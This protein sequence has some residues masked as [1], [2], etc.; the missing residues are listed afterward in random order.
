MLSTR[1]TDPVSY[2][3]ILRKDPAEIKA[4]LDSI[5]INVSEFFR[6]QLLWD[7]MQEVLTKL[8]M[9]KSKATNT[10]LRIWSAACSHGEEPYTIAILLSEALDSLSKRTSTSSPLIT[11]RATDIDRDAINRAE[12]GVYPPQAVRKIAPQI[13]SKYFKKN[14]NNY[15][16]DEGIKRLV[17]FKLHNVV[18]DLPMPYC[19]LI[20]CRN[21]MIY[22]SQETQKNIMEKFW[23]S[24]GTN[25]Y[26]VLGMT[27]S[28]SDAN[29]FEIFDARARIYRKKQL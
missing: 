27:E 18:E 26:L 4:L 23:S 5:S 13:I 15:I 21:L 29:N 17:T 9:E 11:I 3:M 16:I 22:F 19:D 10:T 1:T 7:S 6:D 20:M 14:E 12:A 25:G 24:L 8:L 2:C 28:L